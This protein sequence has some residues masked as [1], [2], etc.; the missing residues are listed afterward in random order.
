MY[1]EIIENVADFYAK[2]DDYVKSGYNHKRGILMYGRPGNGKSFIINNLVHNLIEQE[3]IIAIYFPKY[4]ESFEDLVYNLKEVEPN[5]KIMVIMEDL[6]GL[7]QNGMNK[8]TILNL[9]DGIKQINNICFVATTNYPER[10]EENIINRPSRF[11]QKYELQNPTDDDR[12]AYFKHKILK[13]YKDMYDI[14]KLVTDTK[15]L[16][17]SH[18][19][20]LLITLY[21]YKWDY[22]KCI[23]QLK[24]MSVI[25]KVEKKEIHDNPEAKAISGS[26]DKS[27]SIKE[28]PVCTGCYESNF[29]NIEGYIVEESDSVELNYNEE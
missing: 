6:D 16:T 19:K 27:E 28:S 4:A 5:R 26:G 8:S 24:G 21:V 12:R 22:D 1:K 23:N 11:D 29:V 2:E 7:M 14:E 9:L 15:D 20:E 18:L 25:N 17:M 3:Q 13:E 10:L